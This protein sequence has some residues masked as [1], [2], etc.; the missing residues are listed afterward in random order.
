MT[1]KYERFVNERIY[2]NHS[3]NGRESQVGSG[4][5]AGW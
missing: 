4:F 2:R 3:G 5:E 1:N